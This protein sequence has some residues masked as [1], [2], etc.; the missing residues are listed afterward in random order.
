MSGVTHCYLD[1]GKGSVYEATHL[2]SGVTVAEEVAAGSKENGARVT[3][4]LLFALATKVEAKIPARI[5]R[6]R[7]FEPST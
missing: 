6:R 3:K 5:D 1:P 2:L 4:R 7:R